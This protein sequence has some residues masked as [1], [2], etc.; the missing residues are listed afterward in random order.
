MCCIE[1]GWRGRRKGKRQ[2]YLQERLIYMSM[3]ATTPTIAKA[4]LPATFPAPEAGVVEPEPAA[5]TVMVGWSPVPAEK[6]FSSGES[7]V[8]ESSDAEER[9][10]GEAPAALVREAKEV[11][12]AKLVAEANAELTAREPVEEAPMA[13]PDN[14]DDPDP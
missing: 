12:E 11:P 1:Q 7:E 2:I 14:P 4:A 3:A 13:L 10:E 5:V 6:A 9:D 8:E